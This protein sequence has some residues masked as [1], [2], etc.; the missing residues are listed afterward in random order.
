[1]APIRVGI[2]GFGFSAKTFQLPF[3]LA[4]PED[5][6]VD[7]VYVRSPALLPEISS[8][9]PRATAYFSLQDFF[10]SPVELVVFSTPPH[11]HCEL[12]LA[13]LEAHKHVLVEKPFVTSLKEAESVLLK[14]KEVGRIVCVYQNRRFDSDFRLMRTLIGCSDINAPP[15]FP[16]VAGAATDAPE[17]SSVVVG[18][19]GRVVE[20]TTRYDRFRNSFRNPETGPMWKEDSRVPGT[21]ILFDLGSHL[22]DQVLC[23]FGVPDSVYAV[24]VKDQRGLAAVAA[25]SGHRNTDGSAF[26]PTGDYV[27]MVLRYLGPPELV[28]NVHTGMLVRRAELRFEAH[29]TRG[30]VRKGGLDTQEAALKGVPAGSAAPLSEPGF[31]TEAPADWARLV[32]DGG[33][34]TGEEIRVEPPRGAY[35]ELF[36]QLA[37]AVRAGDGNVSP[38]TPLE[39]W[40]VIRVLEAAM[41]SSATNSVVKLRDGPV[42]PPAGI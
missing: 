22:V 34:S 27:S 14:A 23:L 15:H 38:V 30:S 36:R 6:V 13:A 35:V 11:T 3:F 2:V 7:A 26:A 9:L 28:V 25:S 40:W 39:A 1:M 17:G 18:A 21:S 32:S 24:H 37:R 5:F 20:F 33:A 19:L 41:E 4:L 12:A 31:G 42:Q 10:A 16:S 29:G 8:A